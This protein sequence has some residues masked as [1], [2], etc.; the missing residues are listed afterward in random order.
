MPAEA[1]GSLPMV[2]GLDDVDSS[3]SE[4]M[5]GGIILG[6]LVLAVQAPFI[7]IPAAIFGGQFFIRQFESYRRADFLTKAS[8]QIRTRYMDIVAQQA[9]EFRGK[10]LRDF[11][12]LLDTIE[13]II[14]HQINISAGQ[15]ETLIGEKRR[16]VA[17]DEQ[18][19]ER[20]VG[21]EQ[22]IRELSVKEELR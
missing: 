14:E 8:A 20:L 17:D 19:R 15:L 22:E 12:S 5:G 21:W 3:G 11:Q 4:L 9:S 7:V 6:G 2:I 16:A 18:E 13:E 10:I 1:N